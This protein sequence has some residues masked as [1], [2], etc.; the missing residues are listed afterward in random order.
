MVRVPQ[1]HLREIK[2][3]IP[4]RD[5]QG[6]LSAPALCKRDA[7]P[8]R[9]PHHRPGIPGPAQPV[10]P[11]YPGWRGWR[12]AGSAARGAA[13]PSSP[14]CRRPWPPRRGR[15]AAPSWSR[16]YVTVVTS[17][18]R[19]LTIG[20]LPA[21]RPAPP[22]AGLRAGI[23]EPWDYGSRGAEGFVGSQRDGLMRWHCGH[24]G[25]WRRIACR[26]GWGACLPVGETPQ[27]VCVICSGARSLRRKV[28]PHVQVQHPGHSFLLMASCPI[29]GQS[30]APSC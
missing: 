30:L 19:R 13:S 28:V 29:A 27:P 3:S 6:L 7:T 20:Q 23:A 2:P 9:L 1:R 16:P 15:A 11:P 25:T 22:A 24:R 12:A 8:R 26:R 4:H 5:A 10:P 21:P 14:H 18:A 17:R